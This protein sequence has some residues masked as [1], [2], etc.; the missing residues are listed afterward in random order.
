VA[1]SGTEQAIAANATLDRASGTTSG[2]TDAGPEAHRVRGAAARTGDDPAP[3]GSRTRR[4]LRTAR[5]AAGSAFE[6]LN[7]VARRTDFGGT[8]TATFDQPGRGPGFEALTLGA[9]AHPGA[10]LV[11]RGLAS[12]RSSTRGPGRPINRRINHDEVPR[13]PS[14]L[15]ASPKRSSWVTTKS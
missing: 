12:G 3:A 4:P 9:R 11:G 8:S 14:G 1:A 10:T 15:R 2:V 13:L 5:A 7:P 6:H